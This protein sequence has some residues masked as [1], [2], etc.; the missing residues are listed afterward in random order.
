MAGRR[1]DAKKYE[2]TPSITRE[3][4]GLDDTPSYNFMDGSLKLK[5]DLFKG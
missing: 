1:F 4:Y 2:A 5:S 3:R